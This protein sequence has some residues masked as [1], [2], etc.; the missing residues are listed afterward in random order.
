M[1][2]AQQQATATAAMVA[3]DQSYDALYQAQQKFVLAAGNRYMYSNEMYQ[4]AL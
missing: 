4:L 2:P 1:S 3:L